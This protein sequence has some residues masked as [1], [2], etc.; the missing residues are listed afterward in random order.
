MAIKKISYD[1][2]PQ[3]V[4]DGVKTDK[5]IAKGLWEYE[6]IPINDLSDVLEPPS[7]EGTEDGQAIQRF[8]NAYLRRDEVC[9][10]VVMIAGWILGVRDL[11]VI[12]G[13]HRLT[14]YRM[15]MEEDDTLPKSI[16]CWIPITQVP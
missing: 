4:K 2:L 1:D 15:A 8:K 5:D 12:D 7:E 14:A 6:M 9:P 11:W 13:M 3:C 10:I 16:E